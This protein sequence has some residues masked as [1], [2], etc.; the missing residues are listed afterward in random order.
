M[1]NK[2][3]KEQTKMVVQIWN[4]QDFL[5]IQKIM[6]KYQGKPGFLGESVSRF[7]VTYESSKLLP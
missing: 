2:K 6:E 3:E 1:V 5:G 7:K 4:N